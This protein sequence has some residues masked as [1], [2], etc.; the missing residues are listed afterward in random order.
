[1]LYYN[2]IYFILKRKH[3]S[4]INDTITTP[5]FNGTQ[6]QHWDVIFILFS[7]KEIKLWILKILKE[8]KG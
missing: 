4:H 8:T 7:F 6:K 5:A 3:T 2:S 1:M